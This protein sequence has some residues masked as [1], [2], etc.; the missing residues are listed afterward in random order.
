MSPLRELL[1]EVLKNRN[2]YVMSLEDF[3]RILTADIEDDYEEDQLILDLDD[4]IFL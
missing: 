2:V 1:E 4:E 3:L